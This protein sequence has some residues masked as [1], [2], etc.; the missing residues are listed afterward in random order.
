MKPRL[1]LSAMMLA[2]CGA[3]VTLMFLGYEDA[4]HS[5]SFWLVNPLNLISCCWTLHSSVTSRRKFEKWLKRFD[6]IRTSPESYL[7]KSRQLRELE[8]EL[9]EP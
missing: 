8:K 1:H 2:L 3:G 9:K 6:E 4:S 5:V 7:V